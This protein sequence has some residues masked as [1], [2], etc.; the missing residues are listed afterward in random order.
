MRLIDPAIDTFPEALWWAVSTVS[1]VGYG[2]VVPESGAGR[3]VATALMLTGLGLIPLITSVVV[4]ILVSQRTREAREEEL[5]DLDLILERL[6]AID[7][8]RSPASRRAL[9]HSS[10][11]S[12]KASPKPSVVSEADELAAVLERLRHHRVGE[13]RQDRAARERQH[14]RERA[15]ARPSRRARS[16]PATRAPLTSGDEHPEAH[17]LRRRASRPPS[18]RSWRRSPRAGWRGRRPRSRRR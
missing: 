2:D 18:G 13:H 6:D 16:R 5:R 4:S 17:D 11:D 12:A 3:I 7:R 9:A 1:T 8:Q 10:I 14:E 15:R